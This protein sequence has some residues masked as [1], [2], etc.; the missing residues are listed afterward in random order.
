M[1]FSGCLH[2]CLRSHR[3]FADFSDL[4]L[5][6]WLHM[7]DVWNWL[8]FHQAIWKYFAW[9][10]KY[11]QSYPSRGAK[12][13]SEGDYNI[14]SRL[15]CPA[16]KLPTLFRLPFALDSV[17]SFWDLLL[18]FPSKIYPIKISPKAFLHC[19]QTWKYAMFKL[20]NVNWQWT[21]VLS[22]Q[23]M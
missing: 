3:V 1:L 17:S 10:T 4:R 2:H 11:E 8:L 20:R 21:Q 9:L 18:I 14:Q 16:A 7:L 23:L 5:Y 6:H 19:D 15:R 12:W 13:L 22:E